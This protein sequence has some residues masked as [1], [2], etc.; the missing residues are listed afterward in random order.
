MADNQPVFFVFVG[1]VVFFFFFFCC[2]SV[3]LFSTDV[4]AVI[5][6]QSLRSS[7]PFGYDMVSKRGLILLETTTPVPSRK[8]ILLNSSPLCSST[9]KLPSFLSHL[10]EAFFV[11]LNSQKT[12]PPP[13]RKTT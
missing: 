4:Q 1:G 5:P 13:S 7:F 3:H 10:F 9:K 12:P 6:C 11:F 8:L 2:L